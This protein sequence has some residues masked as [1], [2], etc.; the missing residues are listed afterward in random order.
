LKVQSN[1]SIEDSRGGNL[2]AL[3]V[4]LPIL[5]F[6]AAIDPI[7]NTSKLET[8]E[9]SI[10]YSTD[11]ISSEEI[12]A[13]AS[14]SLVDVLRSTPSLNISQ[15]GG[16]GGSY[17]ISIRGAEARHT[18]VLID[19]IKVN[20][21]STL[22]NSFNMAALTSLDIESIEVI[23]GPQ[24]VLYGSDAIGG[25][26]NIITKKAERGGTASLSSGAINEI[27][28]STSFYGRSNAVYLNAF[29][30]ESESISSLRSDS[31]KDK[32]A[33]KG[34]TLNYSQ[35]FKS[36]EVEWKVKYL[37]SFLQFDNALV[38][39]DIPYSKTINQV[40]SQKLKLKNLSHTLSYIKN[41]RFSKFDPTTQITYSGERVLNEV[42]YTL[43]KGK[44]NSVFGFNHDYST[45][46]QS[47]IENFKVNQYDAFASVESKFQR[48][49][50]TQGLRLTIH[51]QF[52]EKITSSHGV[53]LDLGDRLKL[54]ANF[55]TG[56][57]SP[58]PYQ[59][60]TEDT[61]SFG[62]TLGNDDLE[63][64]TSRSSEISLFKQGVSSFSFTLFDTHI[65]N[66]IDFVSIPSSSNSTFENGNELRT[67]GIDFG[68]SREFSRATVSLNAVLSKSHD[69]KR[70][71]ALKKPGQKV[72]ASLL[73]KVN[74]QNSFAINSYWVSSQYDFNNTEIQ[75]Y[76]VFNLSYSLNLKS[77]ALKLGIQ[78]IFD[79][80]YEEVSGYNTLGLNGFAKLDIKY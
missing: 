5:S 52:N 2:K 57:K 44:L 37:D 40:Y 66:F 41:D 7:I 19:G 8:R 69:S 80:I 72:N 31:E 9:S 18:L 59:L 25:V 65:D 10:T 32:S 50:L 23:K 61:T 67:Y 75:A 45:Y 36:L 11:L 62:T 51:E 60:Y 73:Y 70:E 34:L 46:N 76:D 4:L 55:A 56:F 43:Q 26:I 1:Q 49:I 53:V 13:E 71:F 38:D 30:N 58:T 15:V 47:G 74:D 17:G 39:S 3:L 42:S 21:P 28:N 22:D 79:R 14:T 77:Y 68:A 35:V 16:P 6:A 64:E 29:Y 27:S 78:N 48:V 12:E 54:K 63:P 24:S 20:D 33:N